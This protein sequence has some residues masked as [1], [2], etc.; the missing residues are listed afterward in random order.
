MNRSIVNCFDYLTRQDF[1]VALFRPYVQGKQESADSSATDSGAN[2]SSA[3]PAKVSTPVESEASQA[4]ASRVSTKKDAPTR[5]RA[6]AEAARRER[7]HPTLTPKQQRQQSRRASTI[8]RQRRMAAA[9]NT[10]ERQLMRDYVDSRWNLTEFMLPIAIL[11]MAVSI[12]FARY[13]FIVQICTFVMWALLLL[14][15]L[16]VW[17][18]WRGFKR[19]LRQR[20][21]NASTRGLLGAMLNRMIFIRRF[22]NPPARIKRGEAY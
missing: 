22:R 7:L 19:E 2:A 1:D 18:S 9:E 4:T 11:N 12:A 14:M 17:F 3:R 16:N 10:P 13:L 6:E 21:P 20:Q 8:D 15:I 5:T